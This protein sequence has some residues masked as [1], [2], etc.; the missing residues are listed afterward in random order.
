M[1][2]VDA[3][4]V[5]KVPQGVPAVY[6]GVLAAPVTAARLLAG[7][8]AGEVVVQSG[9]CSL[10]GQA[11]VQLAKAK[12]IVTVNVV[13]GGTD[14]EEVS[15]WESLSQPAHAT[16]PASR[17]DGRWWIFSR[18]WAAMWWFLQSTPPRTSSR[19]S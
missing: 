10:V 16:E 3:G 1:V 6:A 17:R 5:V 12:G 14:E 11:V 8:S 19:P 18:A 9:A 7:V 13:Q 2:N 4:S 15:A